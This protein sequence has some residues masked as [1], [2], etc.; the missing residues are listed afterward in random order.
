MFA[1][2]GVSIVEGWL[3]GIARNE[4]KLEMQDEDEIED[5]VLL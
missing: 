3:Q 5:G 2:S 4:G 1:R